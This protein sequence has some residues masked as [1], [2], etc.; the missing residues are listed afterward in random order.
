MKVSVIIPAYNAK[1]TIDETLASLTS[2]TFQEFEIV[3]VDDGSVDGTADYVRERYPQVRVFSQ[4][5]AGP[6]AA[7]NYG[8]RESQ[9]EWLAF[10][11]ADDAWLPWRLQLQLDLAAKFPDVGMFCGQTTDLVAS[12]PAPSAEQSLA[13]GFVQF[14][15]VADFVSSNPVATTT[16]L[17]K[18]TLFLTCE[19][20]D[21]QF[22]GPEDYELWMRI[23][24]HSA[25][26]KLQYPVSRYRDEVGSL[27]RNHETFLPEVLRVVEKAYAP[28]GV[29]RGHGSKGR[30]LAVQYMGASWMASE[31]QM[32]GAALKLLLRSY[33]A[34]PLPLQIPGKR[35]HLRTILLL[36]ALKGLF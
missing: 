7:R 10:L 33:W 25:V 30:A 31:S 27:S 29:L 26:G 4:A 11:D 24:A 18:R 34:C 16:V 20:F 3:L 15:S 5:N 1:A 12:V 21:T 14:L 9:G 22:I 23:T 2:Q 19:G 6:A 32:N 17:L 8:V 28:G 35:R 36:A 13:D